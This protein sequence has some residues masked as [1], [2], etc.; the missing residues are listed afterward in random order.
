MTH[1]VC[2]KTHWELVDWRVWDTGAWDLAQET[3]VN[4]APALACAARVVDFCPY[5]VLNSHLHTKARD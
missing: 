4:K 1:M 2:L 5:L 3:E